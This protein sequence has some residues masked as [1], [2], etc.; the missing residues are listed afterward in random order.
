MDGHKK[1]RAILT[2][3]D[4][5]CIPAGEHDLKTVQD[6]VKSK[7]PELCDDEVLSKDV[8]KTGD[9]QKAYAHA[10]RYALRDVKGKGRVAKGGWTKW[11]FGEKNKSFLSD[12]ILEETEITD[13]MSIYGNEGNYLDSRFYAFRQGSYIVV[14]TLSLGGGINKQMQEGRALLL[15]RIRDMNYSIEGILTGSKAKNR[16]TGVKY[17]PRERIVKE[18]IEMPPGSLRDWADELWNEARSVASASSGASGNIHRPLRLYLRTDDSPNTVLEC[19]MKGTNISEIVPKP[20][21]REII[22]KA[23]KV[24]AA[25]RRAKEYS[26][27]DDVLRE[28]FV[29]VIR[30]TSWPGWLKIGKTSDLDQRMGGYRTYQPHSEAEF[31]YVTSFESSKAWDIEQAVHA[32]LRANLPVK[33]G[34]ERNGEWYPVDEKEATDAILKCWIH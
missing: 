11:I 18:S 34:P 31:Q 16:K 7:Y 33:D 10:V 6:Y 3:T 32:Y 2:D 13:K 14:H 19:L 8:Y 4:F 5:S 24:R 26:M 28:G 29:Y 1:L 30:N 22:S 15:E 27:A 20:V 23:N 17:S 25:P 21:N 9:G 12:I